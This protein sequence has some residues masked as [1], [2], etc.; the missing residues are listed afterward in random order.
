MTAPAEPTPRATRSSGGGEPP[1]EDSVRRGRAEAAELGRLLDG[2]LVAD[3]EHIGSGAVPGLAPGAVLELM[4]G[5]ASLETGRAAE[6][7][8]A[9]AG[10]HY[11]PPTQDQRPWRRYF[12]KVR[13]GRRVAHLYLLDP[14]SDRWR[15]QLVF[16]DA[17]RGDPALVTEYAALRRARGT[18]FRDDREGHLRAKAAFVGRVLAEHGG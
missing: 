15:R 6:A 16:R 3:V 1:S 9:P 4:A 8:L 5:V 2:L 14:A 12:V 18:E 7:V 13:D 17:L 11:V 10:W